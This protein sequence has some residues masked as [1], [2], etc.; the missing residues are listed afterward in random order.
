MVKIRVTVTVVPEDVYLAA[1]RPT[2]AVP[3]SRARKIPVTCESPE[4]WT[5]GQFANKIKDAYSKTYGR[6]ARSLIL[7]SPQ[8]HLGSSLTILL[9]RDLGIIKYIKDE[10]DADLHADLSVYDALG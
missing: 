5:I 1:Q 7:Q 4:T 2:S 9:V 10:D 6:Y 3:S 8:S